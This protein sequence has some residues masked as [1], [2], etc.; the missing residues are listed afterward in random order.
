[1]DDGTKIQLHLT[2]DR[3]ERSAVFDFNGTGP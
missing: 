3:K 1:M 2:I